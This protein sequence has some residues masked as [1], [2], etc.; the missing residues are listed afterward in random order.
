MPDG[1]GYWPLAANQGVSVL[2]LVAAAVALGGSPV[3]HRRAD[4]WGLVPTVLAT[5]AALLFVLSAHHGLLSLAA[6][7]TRSTRHSR[8]CWRS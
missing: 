5:V 8:S 7:S 4:L 1:A 2:A 3:P 6:M